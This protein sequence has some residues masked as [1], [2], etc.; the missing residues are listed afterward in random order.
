MKQRTLAS[1]DVDTCLGARVRTLRRARGLTQERLAE[2]LDL[3][4]Q[5]VQ[6]YE[7]GVSRISASTILKIAA[8]L[9]VTPASLF[10]AA[11]VETTAQE[12]AQRIALLSDADQGLVSALVDA[13]SSA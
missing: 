2:A 8:V 10:P 1:Q 7:G 13:L 9:S 4:P 6:K 3:S 5:Q 12:L 11:A